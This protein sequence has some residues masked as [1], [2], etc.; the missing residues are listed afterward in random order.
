MYK[1]NRTTDRIQDWDISFKEN[2]DKYWMSKLKQ[3]FFSV[4]IIIF[5]TGNYTYFILPEIF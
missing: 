5:N 4:D 2:T 1:N 3:F